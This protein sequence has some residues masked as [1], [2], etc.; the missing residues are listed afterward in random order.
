MKISGQA[1]VVTGAATGIGFA[2]AE[3][4]ASR[5]CKVMLA[6]IEGEKVKAAAE[7]LRGKA[8]EA[9]AMAC[10][11]SDY[12][13]V[14][15]LAE[16]AEDAFGPI[17]LVFANA[18]VMSSAPVIKYDPREVDWMLG[19]N[20][21]GVWNTCSIFGQ[22]MLKQGSEG[23]LCLTGSEH[24]LGVPHLGGGIYTATKHAV[25]GMADVMRAEMPDAVS[26]H[27]VCPG[28]TSTELY[29][30]QRNSPAGPTPEQAKTMGAKVMSWGLAPSYIAQRALDGIEAGEFLIMTHPHVRAIAER[31]AQDVSAA[32]DAAPE[33]E[34]AEQYS[35][36]ALMARLRGK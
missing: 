7:S 6:D 24:S 13:A 23:A 12:S 32:F 21:K 5:G 18:G 17:R 28:V 22:K 31:R 9:E 26:V 2:M 34:N 15:A 1:A 14:Q 20:I 4:L 8:Y 36:E 25:L 10:D 35:V 11:V 30:S 3:L 33:V 29:D 16:Q 19:V 27:V